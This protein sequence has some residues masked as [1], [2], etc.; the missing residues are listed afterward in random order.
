[1][2][3]YIYN[4]QSDKQKKESKMKITRYA[5]TNRV[6]TAQSDDGRFSWVDYNPEDIKD[7]VDGRT[8]NQMQYCNAQ[9]GWRELP[10]DNN[11]R[12]LVTK[13]LAELENVQNE[14]QAPAPVMVTINH[15][16]ICPKC[17]TYCDGDCETN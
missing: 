7:T 12:I 8:I 6:E 10:V 11:T 15:K 4:N 9:R 16:G 5:T 13:F 2:S 14:T 1:L 17:G 3:Y